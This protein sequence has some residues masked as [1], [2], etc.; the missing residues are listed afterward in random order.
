ML[1][2]PLKDLVPARYRKKVYAGLSLVAIGFTVY[3]AADGDIVQAVAG[4]VAALT[5]ATA[6]SNTDADA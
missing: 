4:F 6:S 3:Q 5:G 2:N 1:S